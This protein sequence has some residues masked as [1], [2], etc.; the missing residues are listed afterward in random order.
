[1]G[2]EV[3]P[4][5]QV[6]RVLVGVGTD[7]STTRWAAVRVKFLSRPTHLS[8]LVLH[9]CGI[10][11]FYS[12]CAISGVM[13]S[14]QFF[15]LAGT[16]HA[17][18]HVAFGNMCS[19]PTQSPSPGIA[20]NFVSLGARF[21]PQ[22]LRCMAWAC[23]VL[24]VLGTFSSPLHFNGP[25]LPLIVEDRHLVPHRREWVEF[26]VIANLSRGQRVGLVGGHSPA[27]LSLRLPSCGILSPR[28]AIVASASWL[29][30]GV[31]GHAPLAVYFTSLQVVCHGMHSTNMFWTGALTCGFG[32]RAAGGTTPGTCSA[33]WLSSSCSAG[34][35]GGVHGGFPAA[36]CA[37]C[38]IAYR[39]CKPSVW[40][41]DPSSLP[42]EVWSAAIRCLSVLALL[43]EHSK[44]ASYRGWL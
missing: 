42:R 4:L 15:P 17:A 21:A 5:W 26:I 44:L 11:E 3:W 2:R 22:H 40:F 35:G 18:E 20:T 36:T 41:L 28:F 29:P 39:H 23:R 19:A 10:P 9:S 14:A 43:F 7:S 38:L 37:R 24:A 33:C 6:L 32:C 12:A 25:T 16:T 8:P 1:M 30:A 27:P 13:Y 31:C 34:Q